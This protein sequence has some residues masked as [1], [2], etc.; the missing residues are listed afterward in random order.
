MDV[1]VV[2]HQFWWEF[3]YPDVDTANELHVPVGRTVNLI[4]HSN[5][6]IQSFWIPTLG[7]KRD[8]IPGHTNFIWLT[9]N[10]TGNFP[11]QCYQLC[12]YSHANMRDRAI[13]QSQPDFDAWLTAHQQPPAQPTDPVA[14]EGAQLFQMTTCPSCHTI[15]GTPAQGKSG[16]T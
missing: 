14:A 3:P 11:G 15:N 5:D 10:S 4:L 8:A 2:G 9:P 1:E 7:G 12:G 13:I 16:P 6:M